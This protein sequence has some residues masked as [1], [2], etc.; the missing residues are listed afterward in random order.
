M[1]VPNN[2][3]VINQLLSMLAAKDHEIAILRASLVAMQESNVVQLDEPQ[4]V[5]NG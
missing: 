4:E 1:E 5:S 3:Q 2:E